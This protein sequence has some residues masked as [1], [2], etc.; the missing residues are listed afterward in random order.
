MGASGPTSSLADDTPSLALE[1]APAGGR[2]VA[3][4]QGDAPGH[5]LVDARLLVDFAHAPLVLRNAAQ[6]IDTVVA[7]QLWIHPLATLLLFHR[8]ALHV[9]LPFVADQVTGDGVPP[10]GP[11]APRPPTRAE[12]G[13]LRI[14]V[15][16][17]LWTSSDDLHDCV[18]LALAATLWAPTATEGY[19]GDGVARAGGAVIA[20]GVHPR[21][22]WAA[23]LGV[24]SRPEVALPGALPTRVGSALDLR[25]A[26]GFFAG[27]GQDLALG[28][29]LAANVT[30]VGARPFDPRA[31]AAQLLATATYRVVGGPFEVGAAVGPAFGD[32]AG[33]PD[34]RALALF[35]F[36]PEAQ[37][38]PRDGDDDGVPD[39]R[40]ACPDLAGVSSGDPVLDGCP[41]APADFDGDAIAD[42]HDACPR[43][44]GEATGE[45]RTHGC[46]PDADG[47]GVPDGSDACPRLAGE[48]PP[49]GN[50]CP[51][52]VEPASAA[53]V[54]ERI[55]I[56]E[57]VQFET[58]KSVLLP[59]SDAVLSEVARVLAEHPDIERCEVQGHTDDTGSPE[60]NLVLSQERAERVVGWLVAHGVAS[61]RLVARG[62]GSE[63]PIADNASDEGRA[64][65]RRVE[66]RVVYATPPPPPPAPTPAPAPGPAAPTPPTQEGSP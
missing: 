33:V 52:P 60:R 20:S 26:A 27:P 13:D 35:G 57:Q 49:D 45:R 42:E 39:T 19:A 6:G 23:N 1:P 56:S 63:Q 12:L 5:L 8:L 17:T 34:L 55:E 65:N 31:T 24:R 40:D 61:E 11:T 4:E 36:A 21:L 29:E 38:P 62:Y 25:V 32:G 59:A 15:R 41:P 7:R 9:D 66:F 10:G 53:L 22:F 18:A 14:G 50:G 37:A 2:T 28:T 44:A 46:P 58:G 48:R 16:G 43:V 64:R 3:V 51:K 30:V 54:A 47:D